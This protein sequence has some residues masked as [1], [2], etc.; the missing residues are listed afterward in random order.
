[1]SHEELLTERLSLRRPAPG[2]IDA[3]F[4]VHS[5]P[6][7]CAHNPS[8]SLATRVEAENLYRR[9]DEHW[10]NFGFGYWVIRRHAAEPQLGFCGLKFMR[11]RQRRI[12]N[13]FYR[14]A[15]PRWG[16]GIAGEAATEV[17]RWATTRFPA[18]P[19]VARVRPDNIASQR[20]AV[21][22]GL[23]RAEHL[24]DRGFDGF[25]LIFVCTWPGQGLSSVDPA[26]DVEGEP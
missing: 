3:I 12:L 13:L 23:A 18:H 21:R 20:V 25:D 2:D 7:A 19:V 17:V 22:A 26:V 11:L 4:T 24:D 15:P 6:L 10:R 5:D 16:E 14:I 8:D 9:W 1:M